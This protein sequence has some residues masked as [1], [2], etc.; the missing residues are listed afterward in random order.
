MNTY[1]NPMVRCYQAWIDA[2]RYAQPVLL[3]A[4]RVLIGVGFIQAGWGKLS[5]IVSTTEYFEGLHIPMPGLNAYMAGG[6]ETVGG[7][8]LI[9]GVASRIITVP[10]IGTM[11]VAYATQHVNVFEC[12][13][14][15]P[16]A[17]IKAFVQAPPFPYL[18]VAL[19]VLLFGPGL[20]SV[21][22]LLARLFRGAKPEVATAAPGIP[23]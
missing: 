22:G 19:V 9:L 13:V 10:L 17:F 4:L 5:N 20:Y 11:I 21:D 23:R 7:F 2:L 15:N 18:T 3:L 6:T 1:S 12:I 16:P 8:L 14:H